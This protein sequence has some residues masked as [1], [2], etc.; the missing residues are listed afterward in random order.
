MRTLSVVAPAKINLTLDVLSKRPDGYHDLESIMQTVDLVDMIVLHLG[1]G[2]PWEIECDCP[3]I[4]CD[5]RNLAWKAA[6]IFCDTM[7]WDP[8]GLRIVIQ[9]V[10]R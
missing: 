7:D 2:R 9:K 6:K 1:T 3:G 5:E 10:I 4:P 8:Q